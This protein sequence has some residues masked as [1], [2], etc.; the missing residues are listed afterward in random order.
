[1]RHF[2]ELLQRIRDI[3]GSERNI[4]QKETDIYAAEMN[5]ANREL[6]NRFEKKEKAA[7]ARAPRVSFHSLIE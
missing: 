5:A 1:M 7:L 4:H 6:I 2:Q 3:G